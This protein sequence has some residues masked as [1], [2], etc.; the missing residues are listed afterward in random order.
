[1]KTEN[2]HRKFIYLMLVTLLA[3][4]ISGCAIIRSVTEGVYGLVG[5]NETAT[6]IASRAQ[7]RSSFAV[8]AADLLEVKRG[9]KLDILEE[10]EVEKV[11]WYHVRANDEDRTEGWIEA[12]NVITG[13]LLEKS[14]KIAAE[15]KNLLPQATAQLKAVSNLRL[16]PEQTDDNIL[17][18]LDNGS[19]FEIVG[20]KYVERK[21]D[22]S[23][24]DNASKNSEKTP[25]SQKTKNA[26]IEAAK[27]AN[28]PDDLDEK[29]DIWYKVRFD[30]SV[31][32]AP[33][34]WIFGRQVELQVPTDISFFQI[35]ATKFV[36]WQRLDEADAGDKA[37]T[38]DKNAA[39][40][41]KP[42]SWVILSRSNQVLSKDGNEPDFDGILVLAYDK[43]NEEHYTI[44]KK[45]EIYRNGAIQGNVPLKIEGS[46]D[47]KVFIVSIRNSAGESVEKRFSVA[48]DA[49]GKIK[50][51]PPADLT[52]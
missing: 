7:I 18:K 24:I 52:N 22:I 3:L 9:A 36:T 42:G 16:T 27:E 8:V 38:K 46:G 35:G 50:V 28:K 6:V 49:K 39:K 31:S 2:L 32:P 13:A 23:E 44:Y 14:K 33:A 12:Q 34:G 29:Y 43:Y 1:M 20:W 41:T 51:T 17:F 5:A 47:N 45:G 40:V 11:H 4:T 19:T 21:Q 25:K 48:K 37:I 26:E 10:T 30:P 15:V